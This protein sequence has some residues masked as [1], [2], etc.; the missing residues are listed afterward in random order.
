MICCCQVKLTLILQEESSCSVQSLRGDEVES[1]H[2]RV[3][4]D[5]D[6]DHGTAI[7]EQRSSFFSYSHN[8]HATSVRFRF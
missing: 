2:V 6:A 1:D 8:V 7:L 4:D 3:R 5:L